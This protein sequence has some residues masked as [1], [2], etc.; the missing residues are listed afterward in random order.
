MDLVVFLAVMFLVRTV[1]IE[2]IGFWGNALFKSVA[3]VG[4]ATLLLYYRKQ[5]WKSMGLTQPDKYIK[6]LGVA[7]ITL[8]LTVMSIMLFEVFIRDLLFGVAEESSKASS[9]FS[10]IEGNIPYLLSILVFVWLESFLEELQDRGF[11]L[12]RFNA[13]FSKI[14]LATV[15]AVLFQAVIFGFRHAYDFSPRSVTTGLIAL[16]FG[17]V[18]VLTGRN[19]WPLIIAHIVLNTMSMIERL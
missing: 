16:V 12:N 5:S 7:A 8:V 18:Y 17:A 15:L 14:P 4:V 2:A 9:R 19:L 1:D 11:S 10:E 6:S 13:L 3:T